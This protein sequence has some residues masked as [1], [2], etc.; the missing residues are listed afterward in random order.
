MDATREDLPRVSIE[1]L[2][3]WRR[4]KYNYERALLEMLDERLAASGL[5]HER[6]SLIPY[7]DEF[8]SSTFQIAKPNVRINGQN[9]EE[10]DDEEEEMEPFDEALDRR[11]W[12][13]ADQRLKW[14]REIASKRQ[15][16]PKEVADM[17]QDLLDRQREDDEE[18]A[19]SATPDTEE[20]AETETDVLDARYPDLQTSFGQLM[21]LSEELQ[22]AAPVQLERS[23]RVRAVEEEVKSLKR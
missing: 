4:I 2:Q 7:I 18:F 15:T 3:D 17:I 12:S 10:I 14:D 11:I 22:Q 21:A 16:R 20:P 23:I 9:S 8:V 19:T 6:D 13:L 5:S 1:T